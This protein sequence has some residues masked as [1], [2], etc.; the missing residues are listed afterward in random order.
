MN[1][2]EHDQP[3]P[4]HRLTEMVAGK[5]PRRRAMLFL[6]CLAIGGGLVIWLVFAVQVSREAARCEQ[7][8]NRLKQLVYGL[9][10]F[11]N[12]D[13]S[14]PPAYLCDEKGKPIHSW[15]ALLM[16]YVGY[17]SGVRL[18]SLK[19]PWNGPNNDKSVRHTRRTHFNAQAP[20]RTTAIVQ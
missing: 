19:E 10:N 5:S 6:I 4:E 8:D 11:D 17:Y 12:A 7:C 9:Y 18:Y 20:T 13:G 14:L 15:Q 16:P 2:P 1:V 3:L